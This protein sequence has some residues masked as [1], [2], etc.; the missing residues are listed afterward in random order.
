MIS[1]QSIIVVSD[2]PLVTRSV[3]SIIESSVEGG[4]QRRLNSLHEVSHELQQTEA[5]T[6]LVDIDGAPHETL[7]DMQALIGRFPLAHFLVIATEQRSEYILKAMQA[8]ARDFLDKSSISTTLP[9]VMHRLT[10]AVS[11]NGQLTHMMITVLAAGGGCGATTFSINLAQELYLLN[12]EPTLVVDLDHSYGGASSALNLSAEFG[13]ADV[14]TDGS[15][16]DGHLIQSTAVTYADGWQMLLS[17]AGTPL[18]RARDM[19]FANLQRALAS[20]RHLYSYTITDASRLP[21]DVTAALVRSSS[22]TLVLFEA[23]VANI[24]STRR[25]LEFLKLANVDESRILP[26]VNRYRKAKVTIKMAKIKKALDREDVLILS[27]DFKGVNASINY[28]KTLADIA[29]RSPFRRD[30]QRLARS[31]ARHHDIN[32]LVKDMR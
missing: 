23:N 14:L 22:L 8:G 28:A 6:I 2:D 1:S 20:A 24:R 21:S 25:L 11:S 31:V 18:D 12:Q 26:V 30:V 16:I 17:P 27:N 32:D 10:P 5:C 19:D 9:D 29:P 15:R 13:I 7:N 3:T 4:H